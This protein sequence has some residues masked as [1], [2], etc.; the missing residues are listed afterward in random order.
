MLLLAAVGMYAVTKSFNV[1]DIAGYQGTLFLL[2]PGVFLGFVYILTIKLRKSPFDIST[3]HHAHQELVK[4]LT[5]EFSGPNLGFLE[6][7][8]WYETIFLLGFIYLFFA[9]NWIIALI[10]IIVVYLLELAIDNTNARVKWQLVIKSSWA[11]TLILGAA[12]I[13]ILYM[14]GRV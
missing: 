10:A 12:N 2:L 11:V 8:H 9:S 5:T 6:I 3:S 1:A 13:A 7:A 14:A 4:G